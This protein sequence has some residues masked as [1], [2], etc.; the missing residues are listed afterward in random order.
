MPNQG[1]YCTY[2]QKIKINEMKENGEKRE[3]NFEICM[4]LADLHF[5][6]SLCFRSLLNHLKVTHTEI[7]QQL[8]AAS[9][10]EYV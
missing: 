3:I 7:N 2:P 10:F 4:F 9:L 6:K 5:E 8:L 1:I